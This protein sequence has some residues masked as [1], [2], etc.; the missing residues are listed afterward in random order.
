MNVR[1]TTSI[2]LIHSSEPTIPAGAFFLPIT[3]SGS[4]IFPFDGSTQF[5]VNRLTEL[6]YTT[7]NG[8][9][10][11]TQQVSLDFSADSVG[12]STICAEN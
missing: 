5:V 7:P 11:I 6:G 12:Y 4:E 10:V 2:D 8:N 1:A 9:P 3:T